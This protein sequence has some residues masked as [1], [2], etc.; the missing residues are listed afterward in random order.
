MDGGVE[1]DINRAGRV[2]ERLEMRLITR[3]RGL[4]DHL[5]CL[6][7]QQLGH[8]KIERLCGL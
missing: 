8:G 4:L 6:L 3:L 7:E 1:T 2:R 5:I